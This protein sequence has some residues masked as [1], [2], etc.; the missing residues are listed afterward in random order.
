MAKKFEKIWPKSRKLTSKH[1]LLSCARTL[2]EA[3]NDLMFVEVGGERKCVVR[4]PIGYRGYGHKIC[5]AHAPFEVYCTKR[6]KKK[7]QRTLF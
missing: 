7:A 1:K 4:K 2:K 6:T 5:P 3:M